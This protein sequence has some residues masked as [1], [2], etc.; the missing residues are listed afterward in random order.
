[1]VVCVALALAIAPL[2]DITALAV[3]VEQ[4]ARV[5][6]ADAPK[7]LPLEL[8][9][10]VHAFADDAKRLSDSLRASEVAED[11]P[12][13]F[14]GMSEDAHRRADGLLSADAVVRAEAGRGLGAL[15]D[16]AMLFAPM[17]A[18]EAADK[19]GAR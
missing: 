6:R 7:T 3:Q 15:L 11:L 14:K 1:M 2:Q 12:C 18:R 9:P 19:A 8:A 16:D 17:A 13:M 4:E 10:R 5:L